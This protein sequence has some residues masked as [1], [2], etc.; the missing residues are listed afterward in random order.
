MSGHRTGTINIQSVGFVILVEGSLVKDHKNVRCERS[1]TERH[2]HQADRETGLKCLIDA[3]TRAPCRPN[4]RPLWTSSH[5]LS[6]S[7]PFT[8]SYTPD[9][10][11]I[12]LLH[13]H[14]CMIDSDIRASWRGGGALVGQLHAAPE[15]P[16]PKTSGSHMSVT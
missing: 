6:R 1:H 13:R 15:I 9:P 7:H 5:S 14:A 16:A 2:R 3:D 10:L 11:S 12:S 8:T 4:H